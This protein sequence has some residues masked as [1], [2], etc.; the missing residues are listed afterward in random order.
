MKVI[1]DQ[2]NFKFCF[3]SF[4][5]LFCHLLCITTWSPRKKKVSSQ[6]KLGHISFFRVFLDQS[7]HRKLYRQNCL[8]PGGRKGTIKKQF[9][10]CKNNLA[11]VRSSTLELYVKPVNGG[12][13]IPLSLISFKYSRQLNF[14]LLI[15]RRKFVSSMLFS[16]EPKGNWCDKAY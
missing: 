8:W 3:S 7:Y 10:I 14:W 12:F 16:L 13:I 1:F 9:Y 2:I 4:W 5:I 15:L 11:R 6:S